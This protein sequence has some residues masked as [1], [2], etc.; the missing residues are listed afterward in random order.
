MIESSDEYIIVLCTVPNRAEANLIT[1]M[2]IDEK[3]TPC[4][5]IIPGLFSVYR[6]KGKICRENELLLVMKTKKIHFDRL[7]AAIKESHSYE[8]P[9]IISFPL[10]AGNPEYLAWIDENTCE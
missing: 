7:S 5:N 4:V 6:W 8:V 9:E 10:T 2:V 3:L 1:E